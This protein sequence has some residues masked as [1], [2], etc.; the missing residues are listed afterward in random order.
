VSNIFKVWLD[1]ERQIIRQRV[2]DEPDLPQFRA[3]LVAT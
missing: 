1:E 2:Y 3:F